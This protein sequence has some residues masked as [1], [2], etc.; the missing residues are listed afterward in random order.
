MLNIYTTEF[1]SAI[2]NKEIVLFGGKW[3]ELEIMV[4]SEMIQPLKDK[5]LVFSLIRGC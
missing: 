2:K 5:C 1:S 3:V 4:L